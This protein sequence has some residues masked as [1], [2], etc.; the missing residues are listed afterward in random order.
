MIYFYQK[1]K[2]AYSALQTRSWLGSEAFYSA[3]VESGDSELPLLIDS[4]PGSH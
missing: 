1:I 4:L 2:H 3:G